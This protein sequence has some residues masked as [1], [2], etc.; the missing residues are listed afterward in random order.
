MCAIFECDFIV[1]TLVL[2]FQALLKW[3]GATEIE[4]TGPGRGGNPEGDV[5][6]SE[7]ARIASE[8]EADAKGPTTIEAGARSPV[9]TTPQAEEP[10]M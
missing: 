2:S 4:G 1:I 9:E 10:K 3:A 8:A 5:D 6:S 7:V